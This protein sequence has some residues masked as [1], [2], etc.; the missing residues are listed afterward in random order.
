MYLDSFRLSRAPFSAGDDPASAYLC[1]DHQR[2]LASLQGVLSNPE[3]DVLVLLTAPDGFGKSTLLGRLLAETG[4]TR[5]CSQVRGRWSEPAEFLRAVVLGFGFDE[6]TASHAQLRHILDVFLRHQSGHRNPPVLVIEDAQNLKP[7][8]LAEVQ[9][10]AA[11]T[12]GERPALDMVLSGPPGLERIV[13]APAM[14]LL[15]ARRRHVVQIRALGENETC[16][17]IRHR[18]KQAGA[19]DGELLFTADAVKRVYRHT[20]GIPGLINTLCETAMSCAGAAGQPRIDV[21]MVES[22]AGKLQTVSEAGARLVQGTRGTDSRVVKNKELGHLVICRE[23]EYLSDYSIQQERVLLG[24]KPDNDLCL[25]GDAVS[26]HHALLLLDADGWLLIDLQSTNGTYVG[27]QRVRQHRL[28]E[29]EVFR[30]ADLHLRC[31]QLYVPER[32]RPAPDPGTDQPDTARLPSGVEEDAGA[33]TRPRP[34]L[35]KSS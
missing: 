26:A 18:L 11:V 20:G 33:P 17:Y 8:V 5:L 19:L 32:R 27:K 14:G 25:E 21:D 12:A 4:S 16:A 28:I 1:D 10:L 3:R 23:D 2:V 15:A 31:Q 29:G 22:A 30:I 35:V 6:C 7:Q 13:A 34:R 24:R 9:W